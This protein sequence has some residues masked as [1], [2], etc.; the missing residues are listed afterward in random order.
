MSKMNEDGE[1]KSREKQEVNEPKKYKV[2]LHNDDYTPMDVVTH[3][4]CSIFNHS[5]V[6]AT[7]IML[8]VHKTG[9]GVA[10]I[11]TK[12]VAEAKLEKAVRVAR[13][14]ESPLQVTMET[15]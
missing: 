6:S 5:A 3:I 2:V 14:F 11:Y 13:Q 7:R 1:L 4:L 9:I 12:E 8:T 10:G 15:E